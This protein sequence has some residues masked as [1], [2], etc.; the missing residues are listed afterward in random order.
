MREL[1]LVMLAVNLPRYGLKKGDLGTIVLTHGRKGFEVE[2]STLDGRT[3]A[4][5]SVTK[6]QVRPIA[7][8]QIAHARPVRAA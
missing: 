4:V 2:F 5:V 1:D 7:R 3:I 8:G 6:D